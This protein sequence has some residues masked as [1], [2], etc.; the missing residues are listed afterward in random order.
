MGSPMPDVR[1]AFR[2]LARRPGFTAAVIVTLGIGIGANTA[3]FS[4]VHA[5]LLRP[6]TFRDPERLVIAWDFQPPLERA[7]LA[8]EER[9]G[10]ER[11]VVI[12]EGLWRRRFGGDRGVIGRTILLDDLP[13]TIIGVLPPRVRGVHPPDVQF[14]GVRDL[15]VP[16]RLDA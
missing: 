13:H 2:M 1:Y 8:E 16:L 7:F 4:L 15:W 3:I 12:S 6:L 9:R 5:V 14:G 11:V 10:S